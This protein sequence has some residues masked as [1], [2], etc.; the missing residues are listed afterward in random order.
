MS[1]SVMTPP[2]P[3]AETIDSP[4][5]EL[6]FDPASLGRSRR[7]VGASMIAAPVLMGIAAV[8]LAAEI[9]AV[10]TSFNDGS[11]VEGIFGAFGLIAF[12]PVYLALSNRLSAYRPRLAGVTR[13]GG[14]V[15][16]AAG[17]T[18]ESLRI[19]CWALAEVGVRPET[20]ERF[21]DEQL[22]YSWP[23]AI[24]V[25]FP[26]T[27][28]LLGFGLK[29]RGLPRWQA[30]ALAVGGLGFVTAMAI[31]VAPKATFLIGA[32]AWVVALI[33]LGLETL[34]QPRTAHGLRP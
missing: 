1:V 4:T 15:G 32:A 8:A 16:A 26:L 7:L 2:L 13:V 14:L 5:G 34:R 18:W 6:P 33:P 31:G 10:P 3:T 25:M 29:R 21:L 9:G 23:L 30:V 20:A 11:W 28:V 22:K 27:S 24:S 12:I 17:V 19:F